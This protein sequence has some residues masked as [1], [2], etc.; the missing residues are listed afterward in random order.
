V[1][2]TVGGRV[3]PAV[4]RDVAYISYLTETKTP[5]GPWWQ[6]AGVYGHG[7]RHVPPG[8]GACPRMRPDLR[9]GAS[10][11]PGRAGW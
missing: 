10:L 6:L 2:R 9:P 4:L 8:D 7:C 11:V 1:Q 5:E 3:I